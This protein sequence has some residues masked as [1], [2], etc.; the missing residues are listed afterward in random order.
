MLSPARLVAIMIGIEDP[1][2]NPARLSIYNFPT[3]FDATLDDTEALFPIGT[4][5]LIREPTYKMSVSGNSAFIRVDSPSDIVFLS[6]DDP[7]LVGIAW[8]CSINNAPK[9]V[10][11]AEGWRSRGGLE[12]KAQRWLAAAVCYTNGLKINPGSTVLLLNRAE[13][14]LRLGWYF[15]ALH[16]AQEALQL[17]PISDPTLNCKA[18]IRTIK[19]NYGLTRYEEVVRIAEENLQN[20]ECKTW[21]DKARKRIT[22]QTRGEYDW[23]E[24]FTC[25]T[26]QDVAEFRGPVEVRE[27][28]GQPGVRGVFVTRDVAVGEL[29]VC[30][31]RILGLWMC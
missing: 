29:L 22:E 21:L 24:L 8:R 16:D 25:D 26:R 4:I 12:F 1:D 10:T 30:A 18:L 31:I 20:S 3:L 19:A 28:D 27:R 11:S 23:Y 7:L 9:L 13:T 6:K 15:S 2:G 17:G 5:L 14:Y